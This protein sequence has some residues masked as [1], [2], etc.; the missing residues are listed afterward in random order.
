MRILKVIRKFE[1]NN[2]QGVPETPVSRHEISR[3]LTEERFSRT[4]MSNASHRFNLNDSVE[5]F[6]YVDI[7]KEGKDFFTLE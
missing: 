4:P 7:E 3:K 5:V 2:F 1:I 6:G